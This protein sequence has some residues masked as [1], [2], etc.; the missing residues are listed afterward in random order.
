MV[1]GVGFEWIFLVF[2]FSMFLIKFGWLDGGVWGVFREEV[3][4][5]LL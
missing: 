2:K 1:L 3:L 4:G 5:G